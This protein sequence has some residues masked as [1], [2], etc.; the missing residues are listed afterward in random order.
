MPNTEPCTRWVD[1]SLTEEKISGYILSGRKS[2][3]L[4][5]NPFLDSRN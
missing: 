2:L 1:A 5:Y 3:P 4:T